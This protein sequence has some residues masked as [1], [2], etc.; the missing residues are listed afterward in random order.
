MPGETQVR[1]FYLLWCE[2]C[3]RASEPAPRPRQ[4]DFVAPA[5]EAMRCNECGRFLLLLESFVA[6]ETTLWHA[7]PGDAWRNVIY[8]DDLPQPRWPDRK[9]GR[10]RWIKP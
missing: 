2:D 9:A 3:A 1:T 7:R 4:P 6:T 8:P 5:T 10:S